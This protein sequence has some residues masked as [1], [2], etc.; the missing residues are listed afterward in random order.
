MD[1]RHSHHRALDAGG[2][3]CF[4]THFGG[5][6]LHGPHNVV[7]PGTT[8][9]IAFETMTYFVIRGIGVLLEQVVCR[10]NHAWRTKATLQPVAF[11][12]SFLQRMQ[13]AVLGQPFDGSD[14]RMVTP[15]RQGG[16]RL[17]ALT[18]DHDHTCA[19][20]AGIAPDVR[21]GQTELFAQ[22]VHQQ[23]AI[24]DVAGMGLAVHCYRN[25]SHA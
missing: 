17:D 19:T 13:V 20:L 1:N 9:Q 23:R 14:M 4:T 24:F 12:E 21:T 3:H 18:I 11:P 15:C 10:H 2:A 5:G 7:V 6:I 25:P 22:V 16:A 8:T